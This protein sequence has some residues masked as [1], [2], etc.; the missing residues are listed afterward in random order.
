MS[1]DPRPLAGAPA[2]TPA[3][4][5]RGLLRRLRRRLHGLAPSLPRLLGGIVLAILLLSAAAGAYAWW[6]HSEVYI[7]TDN[8]YVVGN[9]TPVSAEV[10]GQVVALYTDDNML[11]R[12][13]DPLAEIDPV[14]YQIAVD[15]AAADLAQARADAQAAHLTVQMT[16]SDRQSLLQ[17]AQ[18]KVAEYQQQLESARVQVASRRQVLNRSRELL[19]SLQAQLPGAQAVLQNAQDYR[20]RYSRL[21]SQGFVSVQERDNKEAAYQ[22][23]RAKL[24]SL[25]NNVAAAGRQVEADGALLKEAEVKVKQSDET[26]AQ[27]RAT[28]GQAEASQIQPKVAGA[29]A[30]ALENKVA[31]AE[32]KLRQAKLQLGY[33]LVRAPQDGVISRRTIQLGQ[34]FTA[35]QPFLSIVPLDPDNVWVVANLR[36]DQMKGVRV[37][38]PVQVRLDAIPG[39]TFQAYVESVAGGTGSVF[40]LFPPDNATGNFTRVVQRL[41]VR[42]RFD[43]PAEWTTRIRPGMSAAVTIDTTRLVRQS[44]QEW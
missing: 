3:R 29:T 11:V 10:G 23:A 2:P 34:T 20:D 14:P 21:A 39:R 41:P 38:Q 15:Q 28:L 27:A 32:A 25:Q 4:R 31:L 42:I 44:D 40:S 13:G 30:V 18:A 35:R 1:T 16:E 6:Q 33:T 43:R 24:D 26:L 9:I 36:E 5:G 8:A 12:A 37:G 19:A 17:G 7:S 22:E